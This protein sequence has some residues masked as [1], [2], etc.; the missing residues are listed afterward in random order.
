M[1]NSDD[2]YQQALQFSN[3]IK[4]GFNI[5]SAVTV[6][7][8]GYFH[9]SKLGPVGWIGPHSATHTGENTPT[10]DDDPFK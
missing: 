4:D 7:D 6:L 5:K 9:Q 1:S 3:V 8:A 10:P 2:L